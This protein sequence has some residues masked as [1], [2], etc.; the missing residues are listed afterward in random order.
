MARAAWLA[1]Y[2][3]PE[4][5]KTVLPVRARNSHKGDYGKILLL[6]GST[7]LTG[8]AILAAKAAVRTGSGLVYLG[9]PESVYP[10]CASRCLGPVVFPLPCDA[11]GR[12]SLAAR[13]EIERRMEHMD[14]VLLGP[15]LGRSEEIT[16]LVRWLLGFCHK[17]LVLDADGINAIEGHIDV[18]RGAACPVIVTP[19][20]GEF[21]RLGGDP[22]AQDRVREATDFANRTGCILL[23]KG[24]RTIITDGWN[25]YLSVVG[26]PGMAT[27]G[28]G[29]V[30]SGVIV[31]LL[32]QGVMPLEAAA[33][34]AWLHGSAGDLAAAE[35]G[36]YGM[37]PGDLLT[38]LPRLLR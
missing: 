23:L 34:A 38:R 24:H 21:L 17:P 25:I 8:S 36:E 16:A 27:G 31:S 18:L 22:M 28:S 3:G 37:T 15:G 6:C 11:D 12:L 5:V 4:L 2:V 33:C 1:Q 30:L 32:G 19:H 20:D 9:V 13:P 14:A 26:N 7:G 35:I 10:I 29:D